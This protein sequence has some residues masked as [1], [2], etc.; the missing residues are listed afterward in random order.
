MTQ[1]DFEAL[2]K[3]ATMEKTLNAMYKLLSGNI[4]K[5]WLT[6]QEAADYLRYSEDSIRSMVKNGE[7]MMD[8]HYYKQVKKL[9]FDKKELDRWVMG[10]PSEAQQVI[11]ERILAELEAEIAS[12]A[13]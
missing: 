9:L 7:L 12:L 4:Q 3:I 2:N 10:M 8:V 11:E 6:T 1:V 13:A 5:R